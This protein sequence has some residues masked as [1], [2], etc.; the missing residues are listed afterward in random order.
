MIKTV[1][2]NFFRLKNY[3]YFDNF[4][5]PIFNSLNQCYFLNRN[6]FFFVKKYRRFNFFFFNY[7]F[8]KCYLNKFK[9]Y[10][11]GFSQRNKKF[12]IKKFSNYS[13][14]KLKKRKLYFF[15]YI[16]VNKLKK[17]NFILN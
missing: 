6:I 7:N 3:N 10:F 13:I 11:F 12:I 4:E 14:F 1:N 2:S 16:L 8:Q 15:F 9:I 5:T 17:K